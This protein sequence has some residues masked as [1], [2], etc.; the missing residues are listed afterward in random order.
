MA[1]NPELEIIFIVIYFLNIFLRF[2][3]SFYETVKDKSQSFRHIYKH[4][5]K[6]KVNFIELFNDLITTLLFTYIPFNVNN[7]MNLI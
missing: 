4:F 1:Y 3:E 6:I 2:G 7:L 5:K